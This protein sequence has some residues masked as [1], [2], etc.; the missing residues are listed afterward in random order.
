[1]SLEIDVIDMLER[2]EIQNA[3]PASGGSEINFSCPFS[4]H[5]RGDEKPS[6]YMNASSTAW[7]C[8]GCKQRGKNAA[9]FVMRVRAVSYATAAE[10]LRQA[11]GV[12][13]REPL[14][15]SMAAEIE[16]RF[17]VQQE[18]M[19][20]R[21]PPVSWQENFTES[22]EGSPAYAYAR[23]RGFTD[24]TMSKLGYGYD[25]MSDRLTLPVYSV[26][27]ELVGFKA[28]ALDGIRK[29][30]YLVLGD[31]V[32][33]PRYGFDPY[34]ASHVIYGLNRGRGHRTV[35]ACEGELN[36]DMLGQIG[37]P[38]PVALGMSY[39]TDYHVGLLVQECDELIAFLDSDA[40]GET[41]IQGHEKTAT[42][43]R[44]PGL[45]EKLM[46]YMPVW[47]VP[48]HEGDPCT[49]PAEHSIDLISR[50]RSAMELTISLR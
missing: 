17:G 37:V 28:R 42:G 31:P 6:A 33:K 11:Y 45:V 8:W 38:R 7:F 4:G 5:A 10:W 16:A 46:P 48:A 43:Q 26:D 35:V 36:A 50:A 18:P 44:L 40:A 2:L 41:A 29:P 47:V 49:L 14:G 21:P 30:K 34:E 9:T 23:E 12:D 27:G 39:L 20:L 25:W 3:R 19:R 24:D 22:F 15:G 1:M 13:F 32:D